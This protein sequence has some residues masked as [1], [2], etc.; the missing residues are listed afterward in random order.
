MKA[1]LY[2]SFYVVVNTGT[3]LFIEQRLA[4]EDEDQAILIAGFLSAIESFTEEAV[5]DKI[6]SIELTRKDMV[7]ERYKNVIFVLKGTDPDAEI[8][9]EKFLHEVVKSFILNY[10]TQIQEFNGNVTT[11][12]PFQERLNQLKQDFGLPTIEE[13]LSHFKQSSQTLLLV[14]SLKNEE[15]FSKEKLASPD[16]KHLL[17]EITPVLW[18]SITELFNYV[19]ETPRKLFLSTQNQYMVVVESFKHSRVISYGKQKVPFPEITP[20]G[21]KA[22]LPLKTPLQQL[23]TA[24]NK[25]F[26]TLAL[27]EVNSLHVLTANKTFAYKLLKEQENTSLYFEPKI[28]EEFLFNPFLPIDLLGKQQEN[29]NLRVKEKD[30]HTTKNRQEDLL[31]E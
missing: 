12:Q 24:L 18:Q 15:V 5:Q 10:Y 26:R 9:L 25:G 31:S 17:L 1:L 16:L 22:L 11:F 23:T 30:E 3:P 6:K 20:H 27:G 8:L 28:R 14:Q 19:K 2:D 21:E 7:F 13:Y 4:A 29:T